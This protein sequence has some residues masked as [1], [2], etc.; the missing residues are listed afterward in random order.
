MGG[1]V[2]GSGGLTKNGAGTLVLSATNT[3]TGNT[4]IAA[5]KLTLNKN[6]L[7]NSSDVYLSTV[8]TLDLKFSGPADIIDSLFI[9]GVSQRAGTW[10]AVGSGAQHISSLFTGTGTLQV[11]TFIPLPLVGDYNQDGIV[12]AA[13]YAKWRNN[14]GAATIPNRDPENTG[15]IGQADYTT[16]RARFGQ[17]VLGAGSGESGATG[18]ASAIP[19]P[20]TITLIYWVLIGLTIQTRRRGNIEA[21]AL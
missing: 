6:F 18:S 12:D 2:S 3:Y 21:T 13:D 16:W 7:A 4:T 5:G 11:T 20:A 14:I 10:G 8:A 9:D 17:S 19:E 15:T 1:T